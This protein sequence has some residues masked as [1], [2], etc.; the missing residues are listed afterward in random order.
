MTDQSLSARLHLAQMTQISLV[1]AL[2]CIL[3]PMALPLPISPVPIS[4]TNGILYLC[5]YALGMR[6]TLWAYGIYLLLGAAGLPVFSSY[7]G[8]LAKLTGPTGGY[9]MG[10]L[11]LCLVSGWLMERFAYKTLPSLAAMVLGTALCYIC[12]TYWL[13]EVLDK[14]FWQA[15]LLGIVP[16]IPGDMAKIALAAIAGP[17]INR[18]LERAGIRR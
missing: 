3:A 12:G 17:R 6:K 11:L 18:L 15:S 2:L 8:G 5:L 1:A 14:S 9:L 16:Y 10:F 13:A 4:L 7:S